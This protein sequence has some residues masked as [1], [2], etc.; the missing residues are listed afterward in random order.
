MTPD[1]IPQFIDDLIDLGCE[2][3]ALTGV[4]YVIG[5]ADLPP[6]KFRKVRPALQDIVQRYGDRDHL[7]IE[8]SE[9][10]ISI[11]RCYPAFQ[12]H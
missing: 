3:M 10:L 9:Y 1:Q 7:L 8:I 6:D 12:G 5:D 4:G 2:P 11:G